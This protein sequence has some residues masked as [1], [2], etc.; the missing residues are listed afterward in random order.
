M[1]QET[2]SK[3]KEN[4]DSTLE[5]MILIGNSD[6]TFEEEL[7][8]IYLCPIR[9]IRFTQLFIKSDKGQE[10]V[11]YNKCKSEN[12]R[13]RFENARL[14]LHPW[15]KIWEDRVLVNK[16]FVQKIF[17]K[18]TSNLAKNITLYYQ[19]EPCLRTFDTVRGRSERYANFV[20]SLGGHAIDSVLRPP[21]EVENVLKQGEILFIK[22]K[23]LGLAIG[24]SRRGQLKEKC[25]EYNL[26]F[27]P[28]ETRTLYFSIYADYLNKL[29][30]ENYFKSVLKNPS[31]L[32][33]QKKYQTEEFLNSL[34]LLET[35]DASLNRYFRECC[36]KNKKLFINMKGVGMG[37]IAGVPLYLIFFGRD[38]GWTLSA[39][40]DYGDFQTVKEA[41]Q[42][43]SRF[44]SLEGRIP[45][46]IRDRETLI[47]AGIDDTLLFI[48]SVGE[49]I[50][51]SGDKEFC[52]EIFPRVK[53]ALEWGYSM[54]IN[55]DLLIEHD[56]EWLLKGS[57]WM[58]SYSRAKNGIDV[59]AI[60]YKALQ[61]ASFIARQIGDEIY[62]KWERDAQ[63]VKEEI[64]RRFWNEEEGYLYDRLRPNGSKDKTL[65][66][67]PIIAVLFQA[68][69]DGRAEKILD[70]I[71]KRDF[72]TSWG[73]RSIS[74]RE[75]GYNPLSYHKGSVWPVTTMWTALAEFSNK[76]P[77]KGFE[78]LNILL[79]LIKKHGALAEVYHGDKPE[80]ISR[81]CFEQAWSYA[82]FIRIVIEGLFGLRN[83]NDLLCL[84]PYLPKSWNFMSLRNLK[85]QN[86]VLAFSLRKEK[87]KTIYELKSSNKVNIK[88]GIW[89]SEDKIIINGAPCPQ[90]IKGKA[91]N[92]H[93][94]N[95]KCSDTT[96]IE[97]Q[98]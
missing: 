76:R 71:E 86:S 89:G 27:K 48:I 50:F 42:T 77:E 47:W 45:H 60:W 43:L 41:L 9:L 39:A 83:D 70:R 93:Y 36:L 19:W 16:F 94:L 10:Q 25:L 11:R 64:E 95:L 17:L 52:K 69:K 81:S 73:I 49:Y 61:S 6:G 40:L 28:G 78:L 96:F 65:T 30:F 84:D 82:S 55:G 97:V 51:R 7:Q 62:K 38:Q 18:N 66:A 5:G 26:K 72:W 88:L 1:K 85:F 32:L 87:Q 53:K 13:T 91:K 75:K 14:R 34:P 37:Q 33:K 23:N 92:H 63:K 57:T 4:F 67:N 21:L 3:I 44:Q 74:R 54:D 24:G 12:I 98:E 46:E 90:I 58:D 68:I 29:K 35:P 59:E 56:G 31:A 15:L 22:L 8:G 79:K 80:P 2:S 20:S